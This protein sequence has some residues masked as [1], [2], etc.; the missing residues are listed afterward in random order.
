MIHPILYSWT[1]LS[2]L[3]F[4]HKSTSEKWT[5]RSTERSVLENKLILSEKI[6]F[7]TK[8]SP[9]FF[10]F[11]TVLWG[12]RTAHLPLACCLES[13]QKCVYVWRC[14]CVCVGG[15]DPQ[16]VEQR[17]IK[18]AGCGFYS[19]RGQG[20]FLCLVRSPFSLLDP[21][22]VNVQ[23]EIHRFTLAL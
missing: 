2:R 6:S 14:V 8:K 11:S 15:G 4:H 3:A 13:T 18:S 1:L 19:R 5:G 16:S 9:V 7:E 23:W 17:M 21:T 10:F 12:M 22:R 20:F